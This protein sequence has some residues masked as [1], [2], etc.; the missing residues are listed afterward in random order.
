MSEL[1]KSVIDL[2]AARDGNLNEWAAKQWVGQVKAMLLNLF[3][4]PLS[5]LGFR[6]QGSPKQIQSFTDALGKEKKYMQAYKRHGLSDRRT[7]SVR[8]K[9]NRS[10]EAFEKETGLRWPFK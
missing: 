10:V 6:V 4:V 5:N 3:D 7:L 1:Q 2:N 8:H 9:L